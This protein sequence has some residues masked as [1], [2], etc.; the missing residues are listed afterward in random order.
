MF[1]LRILASFFLWF[2]FYKSFNFK[3]LS[4]GDVYDIF[5]FH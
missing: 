2:F 5:Y 3:S 4:G 1:W